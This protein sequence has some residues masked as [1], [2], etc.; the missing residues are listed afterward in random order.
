[1]SL[2]Q[3]E[4]HHKR[5]RLQRLAK[6]RRWLAIIENVGVREQDALSQSSALLSWEW[7]M[8][9]TQ[10]IYTRDALLFFQASDAG[11]AHNIVRGILDNMAHPARGT[12]TI[13]PAWEAAIDAAL[14][15]RRDR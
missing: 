5:Y 7:L 15:G 4:Y 9:G 14:S 6:D 13:S 2:P 3:F 10:D 8:L 11:A 1:M 12:A